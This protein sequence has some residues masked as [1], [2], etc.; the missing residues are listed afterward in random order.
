MNELASVWPQ[1]SRP[2]VK[3]LAQYSLGVH[4]A[5]GSGLSRVAHCL[6]QWLEEKV[7]AVRERLRDF[8]RDAADKSG[9]R[10]CELVVEDCFPGL[11][12]WV[13]RGWAGQE[14]ALVLDATTLDDRFVVLAVSVVYRG[15]A[16]P[17]AWKI[18][19]ACEPG[20]WKPHWLELL[21]RLGPQVPVSWRVI[22]LADRGLYAKWLFAK[23][24]ALGWHPFLRINSQ[25][26]RF[27]AEGDRG[28]PKNTE[29]HAGGEGGI[30]IIPAVA[31]TPCPDKSLDAL[32]ED[33]VERIERAMRATIPESEAQRNRRI[34]KLAQTLKGVP[35]LANLNPRVLR[36]VVE[37]WHQL[38]LPYIRTKE[39]EET[40]IDF[41]KSWRKVKHPRGKHLNSILERAKAASEPPEVAQFKMGTI[42]LL[43]KICRELQKDAGDNP[44][45]LSVRTAQELL[46]FA[47]HMTA[48]RYLSLLEAEGIIE[49]VV[50]G[51]STSGKANRFRYMGQM[52]ES[53]GDG[54]LRALFGKAAAGMAA[55]GPPGNRAARE[56]KAKFRRDVN[57]LKTGSTSEIMLA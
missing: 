17:V 1:L 50:K 28:L 15:S 32:D 23:I 20:E 4:L 52:P 29:S 38:A 22:V 2:Q 16:I 8:Y 36:D 18:L 11:L 43:V 7:T 12:A 3:V 37:R 19:P 6:G 25:G 56:Q 48:W 21:D 45:F 31:E 24:V 33:V 44:F 34:F 14:L 26:A 10:R 9:H 49:V 40:W 30:G 41:L 13:L 51:G 55:K 47:Q 42:R 5:E 27:R 39:F 46:G 53:A 54:K 35:V 57:L